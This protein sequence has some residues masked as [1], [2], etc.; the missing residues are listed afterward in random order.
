MNLLKNGT[1]LSVV[2]IAHDRKEFILEAIRSIEDQ[3]ADKSKFEVIVIK[4]FVDEKIDRVI[5]S[6]GFTNIFTEENSLSMKIVEAT[7]YCKSDFISFIE[8]DDLFTSNKIDDIFNIFLKYPN[9]SYIHNAYTTIDYDGNKRGFSL[10]LVP[11]SDIVVNIEKSTYHKIVKILKYNPDFNLSSITIRKSIIDETIEALSSIEYSIDVFMFLSALNSKNG[12]MYIGN[13]PLT[14]YR[15]YRK[16]GIAIVP[17][18]GKS[19]GSMIEYIKAQ[20]STE[21]TLIS[22]FQEERV[23]KLL[24]SKIC[25]DKFKLVL[26]DNDFSDKLTLADFLSLLLFGLV[27]MKMYKIQILL[28]GIYYFING[29]RATE[30]YMNSNLVKSKDYPDIQ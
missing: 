28:I 29:N 27:T 18:N 2:I 5:D 9:V 3:T 30:L 20:Y 6:F 15:Y 11:K 1:L 4:K 13:E 17:E 16:K 19:K 26:L 24:L 12:L 25:E 22:K 8:D 23:N 7:Q 21:Q 10:G 14:L